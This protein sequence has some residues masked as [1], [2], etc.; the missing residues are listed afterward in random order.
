MRRPFSFQTK[1]FITFSLLVT[2]IIAIAFSVFYWY[3]QKVNVETI[4]RTYRGEAASITQQLDNSLYTMDRLVMQIK[5][6][7]TIANTFFYMPYQENA[8]SY[9]ENNLEAAYKMREL[10]TSIV[11][12]DPQIFNRVSILSRSGA[13]FG[14]GA[15][16]DKARASKQARES[17]WFNQLSSKSE[18]RLLLPPH[19]DDWDRES[20]REVISVIR[21]LGEDLT[22]NTLVEIQLP[23]EYLDKISSSGQTGSKQVMMISRTGEW[24]FPRNPIL[25]ERF[26]PH[27]QAFLQNSAASPSLPSGN[28]FAWIDMPDGSRDLLIY[29]HAPYSDWTVMIAEPEQE[30]LAPTRQAGYIFSITAFLI[31]LLTLLTLYFST[32]RLLKPLRQLRDT[33]NQVHLDAIPDM[34]ES[35]LFRGVEL[36]NTHNELHHLY[37][38]FRKMLER[39]E[40]SKEQ[41]IEARS[42][43][44]RSHFAAL[45]AQINP[46][47]LY[48]TL[49]LIGAL[50]YET[51]NSSINQLSTMLV[52][53]FRYITYAGGQPVTLR[54]EIRHTLNYLNIM[55]IRYEDHLDFVIDVDER[56]LE[57]SLP[58]ITLQPFVENCFKHG[59][60]NTN[61]PWKI[62]ITGYERDQ[63]QFIEIRD[64]GCGFSESYLVDFAEQAAEVA[65]G[66]FS[67]Y[68]PTSR[69]QKDSGTPDEWKEESGAGTINT[70]ARLYYHFGSRVCLELLNG[71]DQGAIVRI[72]WWKGTQLHAAQ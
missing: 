31:I 59:F 14:T 56:L 18:Y 63:R 41:S 39:L 38:S 30:L 43:E 17:P 72:G 45:Q 48:N 50:G 6:N 26:E 37:Q 10:I 15:Y 8:E 52:G 40:E 70:Y 1:L 12:L 21:K 29:Q 7:P 9:F 49:S 32:K 51:G 65:A 61:Y 35:K 23:A 44:L 36:Q 67:V 58:K 20:N 42:R 71:E 54:E 46:H 53:M 5:Y 22:P 66:T 4:I 3:Y 57:Q 55:K 13:F 25:T 27:R 69:A 16:Y 34:R 19:R 47:F 2:M 60:A 68:S 33:M 24:I 28:E 11:G 64:D 62:T